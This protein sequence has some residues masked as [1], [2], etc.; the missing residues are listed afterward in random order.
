MTVEKKVASG[1]DRCP[2]DIECH[3]IGD[4]NG[5]DK[6]IALDSK[7]NQLNDI[8]DPNV[9]GYCFI[10]ELREKSPE[11]D[12]KLW[13]ELISIGRR[14]EPN[15]AGENFGVNKLSKPFLHAIMGT[16]QYYGATEKQLN[17]TWQ[18]L[19][20][21][22]YR[23][24]DWLGMCYTGALWADGRTFT[25]IE[26]MVKLYIAQEDVGGFCWWL[27]GHDLD[28]EE[29]RRCGDCINSYRNWLKEIK[30]KGKNP[31]DYS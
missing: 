2:T 17:Q 23:I 31:N 12:R 20:I 10:K 16:L 27:R 30:D 19:A 25:C 5:V 7:G 3:V 9:E 13:N 18:D 14:I 26:N 22:R 1:K 15:N 11:Y 6:V 4:E 29:P 21:A 8:E 24:W 28:V